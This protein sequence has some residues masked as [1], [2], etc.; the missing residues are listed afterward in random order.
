MVAI[1]IIGAPAVKKDG[2]FVC[3]AGQSDG[4]LDF[5]KTFAIHFR[6]AGAVD[7][8]DGA[9]VLEPEL[10]GLRGERCEVGLVEVRT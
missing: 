9:D 6:G 7:G 3:I 2:G 8:G 1:G 5:D 10:R 4:L